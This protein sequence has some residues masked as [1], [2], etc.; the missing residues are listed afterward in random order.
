MAIYWSLTAP[1]LLSGFI[2]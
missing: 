1:W 2:W